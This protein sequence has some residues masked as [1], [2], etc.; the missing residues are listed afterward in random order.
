MVGIKVL[1]QVSRS[2]NGVGAFVLPCK[3]ITLQYCN[4]GGSSEGMRD[5]LR[6]RLPKFAA[7]HPE[8]EFRVVEKPGK[9]P[10]VKGEYSTPNA[11]VNNYENDTFKQI[12]VRK[13][14]IDVIE[15]K[16][17]LLVNSSGKKLSKP[18]HTVVSSNPSVRGIWSPF[19]VD[20]KHRFRV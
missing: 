11:N 3:R 18:K 17:K 10:I 8:I 20:P 5:F 6:Q 13:W 16:L 1:Q 12:C 2:R 15:N 19:Y 4:F 9:H 7:R 14:N